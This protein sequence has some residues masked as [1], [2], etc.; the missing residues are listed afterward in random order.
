[1]FLEEEQTID[2]I[3]EQLGYF[4]VVDQDATCR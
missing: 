2:R 3:R 1:M 4:Q